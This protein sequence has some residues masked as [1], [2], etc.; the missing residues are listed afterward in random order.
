MPQ[1]NNT[2]AKIIHMPQLPGAQAIT[3]EEIGEKLNRTLRTLETLQRLNHTLDLETLLEMF[4]QELTAEL[5]LDGVEYHY[6]IDDIILKI[7]RQSQQS[8]FYNLILE[9]QEFGKITFRRRKIFTQEEMKTLEDHLFALVYPLRN[10]ILYRR[11]LKLAHRDAL[12][13]LPNRTTLTQQL[14]NEINSS[15]RYGTTLSLMVIDIDRF[16]V[17]N[18]KYGHLSGDKILTTVSRILLDNIRSADLAFRYAGDEF[19]MLLRNTDLQGADLA[20]RRIQS[21]INKAVFP[22]INV[23][24]V[25]PTVSIGITELRADDDA[26]SLFERADEAMYDAKARGRNRIFGI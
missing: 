14:N 17:I 11:A 15:V 6:E 10:A 8:C 26:T 3:Q 5:P 13:G 21:A 18:D 19:V 22:T 1:P 24:T 20:A 16:K 4:Y 23:T 12:T 2:A 7:G 25:R 9:K